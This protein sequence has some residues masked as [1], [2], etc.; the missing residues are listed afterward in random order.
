MQQ[1]QIQDD[2]PEKRKVGSSTLPLTT[3]DIA[4]LA[5]GNAEREAILMPFEPYPSW[6]KKPPQKLH[7]G[8]GRGA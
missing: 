5:S 7:T 3:L 1:R 8:Q 6:L 4:P 2:P